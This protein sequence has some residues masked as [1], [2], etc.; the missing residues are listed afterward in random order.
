MIY[1]YK[2][3]GAEG[4]AVIWKANAYHVMGQIPCAYVFDL[5]TIVHH[6]P[7]YLF[8]AIK[9]HFNVKKS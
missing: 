9:I 8:T 3:L 5:K 7:F 2:Q 1:C 4:C 6:C